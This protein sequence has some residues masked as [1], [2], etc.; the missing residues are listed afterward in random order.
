MFKKLTFALTWG[1]I[2]VFMSRQGYRGVYVPD[3]AT[4]EDV[5]AQE[6][7]WGFAQVIAVLLLALPVVGFYG[8]C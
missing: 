1:T 7:V 6:G 2:R 8:E 5:L 3:E 4:L